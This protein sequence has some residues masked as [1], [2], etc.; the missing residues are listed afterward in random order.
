[1]GD[2]IGDVEKEK[3][4]V[5]REERVAVDSPLKVGG[6]LLA[7]T[8]LDVILLGVLRLREVWLVVAVAA[9]VGVRE[10]TPL[11]VI[12]TDEDRDCL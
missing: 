8:V 9:V 5:T 3:A 7:S 10:A 4:A 12:A 6:E 11:G 1:M 2:I